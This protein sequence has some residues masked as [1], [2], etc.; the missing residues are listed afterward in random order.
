[1]GAGPD[2]FIAVDGVDHVRVIG[3]DGSA[4]NGVAQ[5]PCAERGKGLE[6]ELQAHP[7]LADLGASLRQ[8]GGNAHAR[9]GQRSRSAA[10]ARTGRKK[11]GRCL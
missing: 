11:G 1:M 8:I 2:D 9:E 5:A 4:T 7:N 10:D 6:P 3:G